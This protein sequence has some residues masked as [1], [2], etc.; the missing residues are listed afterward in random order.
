MLEY[1]F[2]IYKVSPTGTLSLIQDADNFR[3]AFASTFDFVIAKSGQYIVRSPSGQTTIELA[4]FETID[5]EVAASRMAS[6]V[7]DGEELLIN[8]EIR[9]GDFKCYSGRAEEFSSKDYRFAA[10]ESFGDTK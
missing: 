7:R 9:S 2:G 6:D 4:D 8:K 3:T 10:E 5:H 1:N